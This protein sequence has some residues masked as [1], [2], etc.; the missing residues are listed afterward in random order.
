MLT[1]FD[2][3]KNGYIELQEVNDKFYA[4]R[5]FIANNFHKFDKN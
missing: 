3:D 4:D 5:D 1:K 2:L